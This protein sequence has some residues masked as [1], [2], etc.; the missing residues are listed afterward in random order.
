[1]TTPKRW[2]AERLASAPRSLRECLES[3]VADTP[4]DGSLGA[5]LRECGERMLCEAT[6]G[7]ADRQTALKLLAADA[8]I[9]LACEH[10]ATF[11]ETDGDGR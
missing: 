3:A 7:A 9:T 4:T 1:M 11:E 6:T 2:L 5:F 10:D 8:L